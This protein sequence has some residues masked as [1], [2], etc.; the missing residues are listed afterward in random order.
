PEVPTR[1][2]LFLPLGKHSAGSYNGI[3]SEPVPYG[4][5]CPV[6]RRLL[7]V[8]VE[9]GELPPDPSLQPLSLNSLLKWDLG[10]IFGH[11]VVK[12]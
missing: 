5:H 6:D 3:L 2:I 7:P 4:V 11:F 8:V 9:E 12:R 1:A 10:S